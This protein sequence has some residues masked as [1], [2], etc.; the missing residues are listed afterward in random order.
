MTT[1]K[2]CYETFHALRLRVLELTHSIDVIVLDKECN[3]WTTVE[4]LQGVANELEHLEKCLKVNVARIA[5]IAIPA[6]TAVCR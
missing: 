4:T 3:D 1:D 5:C 2:H 6:A